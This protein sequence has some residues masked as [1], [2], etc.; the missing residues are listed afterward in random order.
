MLCN[1]LVTRFTLYEPKETIFSEV[2]K[3]NALQTLFMKGVGG[4]AGGGGVKNLFTLVGK[5]LQV[6]HAE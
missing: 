6:N 2:Q 5:N 4:G 1:I 3:A